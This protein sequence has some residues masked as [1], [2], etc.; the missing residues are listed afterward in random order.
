MGC[1]CKKNKQVVETP[2]TINVT[3]SEQ[4]GKQ[5]TPNQEVLVNQIVENLNKIG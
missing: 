2:Q 5:L 3:M 1:G 4:G